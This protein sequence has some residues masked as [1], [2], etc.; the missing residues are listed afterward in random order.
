MSVKN[1][2]GT[3]IWTEN[4]QESGFPD[5]VVTSLHYLNGI[6]TSVIQNQGNQPT[7]YGVIG[8]GYWVDGVQKTWGAAT[9]SLGIGESISIGTNGGY[10]TVPNGNHTIMAFVDDVNSIVESDESNN[11]YSQT[12]YD[13]I[14]AIN[15]VG[16]DCKTVLF[17]NSTKNL[18]TIKISNEIE[19]TNIQIFDISG[20]IVKEFKISGTSTIDITDIPNGLYIIRLKNILLK[21]LNL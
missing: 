1:G 10:Y 13:G 18:Q 6:F 14:A 2:I 15:N 3:F 4:C 21:F 9:V 20:M 8:V 19:N 7:P 12:I 16:S 17:L 5:L 11:K